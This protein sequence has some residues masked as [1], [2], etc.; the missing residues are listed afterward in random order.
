[1]IFFSPALSPLP[2]KDTRSDPTL[3][4]FVDGDVDGRMPL[5]PDGGLAVDLFDGGDQIAGFRRT[6]RFRDERLAE[7]ISAPFRRV[8]GHAKFVVGARLQPGNHFTGGR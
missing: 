5:D 6:F 4:V 8:S 7:E 3:L 1:M 2:I